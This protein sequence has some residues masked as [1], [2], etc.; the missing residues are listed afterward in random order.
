MS[1][2]RVDLGIDAEDPTMPKEFV[3]AT[4]ASGSGTD[5]EKKGPKPEEVSFFRKYVRISLQPP[6]SP[7]AIF[8]LAA[9][10]LSSVPYRPDPTA[11]DF[12]LQWYVWPFVMMLM[13][14]GGEPPK[15]K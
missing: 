13:M 9:A 11:S 1:T 14:G 2:V 12:W 8:Q 4:T 15:K 6:S 7:P 5:G 10:S 3:E